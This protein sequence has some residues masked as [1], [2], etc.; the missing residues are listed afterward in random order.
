MV[1]QT[2]K[3]Q[4][5]I[6]V[7]V[8]SRCR[9]SWLIA[10]NVMTT[11]KSSFLGMQPYDQNSSTLILHTGKTG[12]GFVHDFFVQNQIHFDQ[13]HV[14]PISAAA[15]SPG[16][17]RSIVALVRD[18]VSRFVSTFNSLHLYEAGCWASADEALQMHINMT[19]SPSFEYEHQSDCNV[20]AATLFEVWQP[21]RTVIGTTGKKRYM[22]HVDMNFCFYYGG[23]IWKLLQQWAGDL[24][25]MTVET[26]DADKA[27]MLDWVKNRGAR[28]LGGVPPN[29]QGHP[30]QSYGSTA[31]TASSRAV[32]E[33]GL[34]DEYL[35]VNALLSSSANKHGLAYCTEVS[36]IRHVCFNSPSAEQKSVRHL[37]VL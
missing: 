14:H 5:P 1:L 33:E 6:Q 9:Q 23:I 7:T 19:G 21:D 16:R 8:S 15:I 18:P 11:G 10:I 29:S 37:R 25:V 28:V 12:G 13:V 20:I 22:G 27:G 32:A 26:L 24:F 30:H 35:I 36:T 4:P 17:R 31:L 2:L 34:A 3:Q